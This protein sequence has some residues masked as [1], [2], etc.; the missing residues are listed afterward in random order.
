M[1]NS[2]EDEYFTWLDKF[3]SLLKGVTENINNDASF[4]HLLNVYEEI[5]SREYSTCFHDKVKAVMLKNHIKKTLN[6][7]HF[8][9]RNYKETVSD[10]YLYL[11]KMTDILKVYLDLQVE[12]NCKLVNS[13]DIITA[14][15]LYLDNSEEHIFKILLKGK[16][17]TEELK[18]LY[19]PIFAKFL[20]NFENTEE[21]I[22][23]F[24]Y[25]RYLLAFKLWE[26][27]VDNSDEQLKIKN[28]AQQK[29]G[30]LMPQMD[31]ELLNIISK[32]PNGHMNAT[33]WLMK[34]SLVGLQKICNDFLE[35]EE[36]IHSFCDVE[37][38]DVKNSLEEKLSP[39]KKKM[40]RTVPKLKKNQLLLIDLTNDNDEIKEIITN[41]EKPIKRSICIDLTSDNVDLKE[42]TKKQR[43]IKR[44]QWLNEIKIQKTN[45]KNKSKKS[46]SIT[47][48]IKISEKDTSSNE[49]CEMIDD[50][51]SE[52]IHQKSDVTFNNSNEINSDLVNAST[53]L[54]NDSYNEKSSDSHHD[55]VDSST[56][57]V[58]S[59]CDHFN[60]SVLVPELEKNDFND[61]WRSTTFEDYLSE[62]TSCIETDSYKTFQEEISNEQFFGEPSNLIN[63]NQLFEKNLL[64]REILNYSS[65]KFFPSDV[66]F[67]KKTEKIT[68]KTENDKNNMNQVSSSLKFF[69]S[70]EQ[71]INPNLLKNTK[72]SAEFVEIGDKNDMNEV[73]SSLNKFF[74]SNDQGI[75]SNLNLK[76]AEE[77]KEFEENKI[78][79]DNKNDLNEVSSSP[80]KFFYSTDQGINPNLLFLKKIEELNDSEREFMENKIDISEDFEENE[81]FF[82][83]NDMN[84]QNEVSST[85]SS[86]YKKSYIRSY[87]KEVKSNISFDLE[88]FVQQLLPFKK[89]YLQ[90]GIHENGLSLFN[91]ADL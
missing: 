36:K 28:M 79:I 7:F 90:G 6:F 33:W 8:Y 69:Y 37:K 64:L 68:D 89:R 51:N 38:F 2:D 59:V 42:I 5:I 12:I 74:S 54:I 10:R 13:S 70:T 32:S 55:V 20:S 71:E 35:L 46:Q 41:K 4:G 76:K 27:I 9:W 21:S 47:K 45:L 34:Y 65:S 24:T 1:N 25:I 60:S 57:F 53:I 15:C 82:D 83:S 19:C 72:E 80:D 23:D 81:E 3:A 62:S 43:L 31:L 26:R 63:E 11:N 49:N 22:K 52:N 16:Y 48:R 61:F 91:K 85:S 18:K 75:C 84:E 58:N 29:L 66:N 73:S 86:H 88:Q 67:L 14:L 39:V 56:T 30:F 87:L 50:N 44:P 40:K 17:E 77:C 78:D